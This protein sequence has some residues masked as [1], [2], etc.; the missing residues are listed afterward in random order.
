[1]TNFDDKGENILENIR[2]ETRITKSR[3]CEEQKFLA[4]VSLAFLPM[5]THIFGTASDGK[6]K[7]KKKN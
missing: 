2:S 7:Q 6:A 3:N 4:P 5:H 1:L